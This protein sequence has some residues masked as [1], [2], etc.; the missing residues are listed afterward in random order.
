[1]GAI[2]GTLIRISRP[3]EDCDP[4]GFHCRKGY[5]AINVQA[6]CDFRGIFRDVLIGWPGRA[7]D[8]RVLRCSPLWDN[9]ESTHPLFDSERYHLLGDGGYQQK[10]WLLL[11]YSD[12]NTNTKRR[13]N[14]AHSGARMVIERAFGRLKAR[15]RC[16][17]YLDLD[18][19]A[20]SSAFIH[21]CFILHNVAEL[22]Q[23]LWDDS[24]SDSDSGFSASDDDDDDEDDGGYDGPQG[25]AKRDNI[26]ANLPRDFPLYHSYHPSDTKESFSSSTGASSYQVVPRGQ[27]RMQAEYVVIKTF[28]RIPT[29]DLFLFV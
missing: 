13:F 29:V 23:D 5:H 20:L 4:D 12:S 16:L 1:V 27:L 26:A 7:T 14:F 9:M 15:W 11:P 21:C 3:H 28:P 17:R 19:V 10:E 6:V 18:T 2:D 24:D 25:E 22:E 8:K